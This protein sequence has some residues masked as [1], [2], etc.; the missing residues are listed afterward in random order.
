MDDIDA[1]L[2]DQDGLYVGGGKHRK[3]AR[4]L[5]LARRRQ[6][7]ESA[8]EG[9]V[10][11]AGCRACANCCSKASLTDSFSLDLTPLKDG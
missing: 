1:F 11:L 9:G 2:L 3:H 4:D 5:A 7:A 6:G 10:L 8:W